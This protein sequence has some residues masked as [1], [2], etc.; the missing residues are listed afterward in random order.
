MAVEIETK[1]KVDGLA[2]VRETLHR[3]RAEYVAHQDQTDLY[4]DN[5][6][7][8]MVEQDKCLR[9]RI[10]TTGQDTK[11]F[12]T[13]KGPRQETDIKCRQEIEWPVPDVDQATCLLEGLGYTQRLT[14]HKLRELWSYKQCLVGLDQVTDLGPFVEIEGPNSNAI[15][16]VQKDLELSHVSHCQESYAC[17][18]ARHQKPTPNNE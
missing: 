17:L 2:H 4:C 11:T 13:F 15:R 8:D 16:R 3:I 7:E 18:L 14:V 6:Q 12:I 1:L 5:D 9:V 10:E